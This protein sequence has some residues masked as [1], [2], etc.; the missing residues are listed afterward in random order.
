[1]REVLVGIEW[2]PQFTLLEFPNLPVEFRST[3]ESPYKPFLKIDK[4]KK[5]ITVYVSKY[6]F[7]K[8]TSGRWPTEH[9]FV[10]TDEVKHN[11]E[12]R[13]YPT[14]PEKLSEQ[15]NFCND[16]LG[17]FMTIL[18]GHT[19]S[20]AGVFLPI[21]GL[22]NEEDIGFM[23]ELDQYRFIRHHTPSKHFSISFNKVSE[24]PTII[25]WSDSLAL[26][27]SKSKEYASL[28][29]FKSFI[30][31]K[32]AYSVDKAYGLRIH[33]N[34]PYN[35]TQ[36]EK[37]IPLA[38]KLWTSTNSNWLGSYLSLARYIDDWYKKNKQSEPIFVGYAKKDKYN[39]VGGLI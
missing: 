32:P 7:D 36:Y 14:S 26:E 16:Y 23:D 19:K 20:G 39:I 25:N 38:G 31:C 30:M 15:I 12:V 2:E 8:Y 11:L 22:H 37:L 9:F 34:I 6:L 27:L 18:G 17:K 10:S 5:I 29:N 13:T 33:I 1:M 3:C 4:N 24:P 28:S 35:F 21:T